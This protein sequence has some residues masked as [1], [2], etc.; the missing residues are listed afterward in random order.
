MFP[1]ALD[2][3]PAA[4]PTFTGLAIAPQHAANPTLTAIGM[5]EVHTDLTAA[6][7]VLLTFVF[8]CRRETTLLLHLVASPEQS[9][10][11]SESVAH[12]ASPLP[13][14]PGIITSSSF[15]PP[16]LLICPLMGGRHL[17]V[18]QFLSF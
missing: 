14:V 13:T 9:L 16:S 1:L 3:S 6:A 5:F 7:V 15:C 17:I 12:V 4:S 2:P 11:I 10:Q 18:S 8:I